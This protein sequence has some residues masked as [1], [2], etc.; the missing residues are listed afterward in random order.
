MKNPAIQ[1]AMR[2]IAHKV[3]IP[4][5]AREMGVRVKAT[6]SGIKVVDKNEERN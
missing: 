3:Y 4:K 5:R 2:A 1:N 6:D